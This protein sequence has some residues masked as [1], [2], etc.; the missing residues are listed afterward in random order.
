[1]TSLIKR[2]PAGKAFNNAFAVKCF[3]FLWF[4]LLILNLYQRGHIESWYIEQM[5]VI[6]KTGALIVLP[7]IHTE[8]KRKKF[9]APFEE[10][11]SI[12]NLAK[13]YVSISWRSIKFHDLLKVSTGTWNSLHGSL[14]Y[15]KLSFLKMKKN[16]EKRERKWKNEKCKKSQT[17]TVNIF[18]F[19]LCIWTENYFVWKYCLEKPSL[20]H[21]IC[22][23]VFY[24]LHDIGNSLMKHQGPYRFTLIL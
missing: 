19:P 4:N 15:H 8:N 24:R 13:F 21:N 16:I 3:R 10:E 23:I 12:Q 17:A 7:I 18:T 22:G 14:K 9:W 2:I 5:C 20:Y 6:V 1:M 11:N